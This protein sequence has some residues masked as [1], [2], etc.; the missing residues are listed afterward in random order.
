MKRIPHFAEKRNTGENCSAALGGYPS[1]LHLVLSG[2]SCVHAEVDNDRVFQSNASR[3]AAAA[4][5]LV[6]VPGWA[7][8]MQDCSLVDLSYGHSS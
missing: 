7:P 6:Y 8:R 5:G 1:P 3:A 2:A 4:H